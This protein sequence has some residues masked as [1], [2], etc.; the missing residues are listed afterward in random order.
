MIGLYFL[1][2]KK[3]IGLL[4][5]ITS[6]YLNMAKTGPIFQ[7]CYIVLIILVYQLQ[8]INCHMTTLDNTGCLT[9][10]LETTVQII[11]FISRPK[12]VECDFQRLP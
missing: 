9:P 1:W 8:K 6:Y 4:Y 3:K 7:R 2:N 5:I 12:V 10:T 11:I